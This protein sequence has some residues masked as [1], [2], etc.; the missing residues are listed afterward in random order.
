MKIGRVA[1][2]KE[3]EERT[4]PDEFT[5]EMKGND[6]DSTL[7]YNEYYRTNDEERFRFI[8]EETKKDL[9]APGTAVENIEYEKGVGKITVRVSGTRAQLL[10]A[11]FRE[12]L[13]QLQFYYESDAIREF[14]DYVKVYESREED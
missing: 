8:S 11:L 7:T 5:L 14:F 12:I 4:I 1:V 2:L 9:N 6:S 10:E 3:I 13:L